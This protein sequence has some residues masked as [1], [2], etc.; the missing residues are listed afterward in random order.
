MNEP[1]YH[2]EVKGPDQ[3]HSWS[4]PN[5]AKGF[6]V[7][8][9]LGDLRYYLKPHGISERSISKCFEQVDIDY[10][11]IKKFSMTSEVPMTRI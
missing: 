10:Y 8:E 5:T 4:N 6:T 9:R 11:L 1:N 3:L 7:M 2:A